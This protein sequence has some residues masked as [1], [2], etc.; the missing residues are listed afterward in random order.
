MFPFVTHL[1]TEAA[2]RQNNNET[3]QECVR[4]SAGTER[5]GSNSSKKKDKSHECRNGGK[6][7]DTPGNVLWERRA[8]VKK[9]SWIP[10]FSFLSC[11]ETRKEL[12]KIKWQQI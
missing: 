9:T 12:G 4:K 11:E 7:K 6:Q 5:Q 3:V 2:A 1:T 10:L 8:G